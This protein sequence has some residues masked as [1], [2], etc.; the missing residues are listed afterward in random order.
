MKDQEKK[1]KLNDQNQASR[2]NTNS[3]TELNIE[4]Y[5]KFL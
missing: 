5:N 3:K 4:V 1:I 2:S